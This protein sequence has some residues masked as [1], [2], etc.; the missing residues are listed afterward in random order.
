MDSMHAY[1]IYPATRYLPLK[2]KIHIDFLIDHF[3]DEPYGIA[4]NLDALWFGGLVV[5]CY[6]K[7]V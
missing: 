2:V 3:R 4:Y 6:E 5:W 7:S 1:A